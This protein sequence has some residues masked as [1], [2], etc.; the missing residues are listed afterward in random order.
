MANNDFVM[1]LALLS[2]PTAWAV[3]GNRRSP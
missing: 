3:S 1:V 2:P